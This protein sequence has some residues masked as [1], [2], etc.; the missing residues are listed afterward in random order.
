MDLIRGE[1]AEEEESANGSRWGVA[2]KEENRLG[3]FGQSLSGQIGSTAPVREEPSVAAG[4]GGMSDFSESEGDNA[5]VIDH[6]DGGGHLGPDQNVVIEDRVDS[7]DGASAQSTGKMD[8]Q[9][10]GWTKSYSTWS[11]LISK[12]QAC[13]QTWCPR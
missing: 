5:D 4:G 11:G 10:P 13:K 7:G 9:V 1:A 6:G 3:G 12:P 8:P 2:D